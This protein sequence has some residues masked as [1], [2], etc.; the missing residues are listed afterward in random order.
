[1]A[2]KACDCPTWGLFDQF[3]R[4]Y[5]LADLMEWAWAIHQVDLTLLARGEH[6]AICEL[7]TM[8]PGE[9]RVRKVMEHLCQWADRSRVPLELS[10]SDLW[11]ADIER[12]IRFYTS[13]GF[14]LNR[15][16]RTLLRLQEHMIRY[17]T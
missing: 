6:V 12:L 14:Q 16:P 5:I 2:E 3:E 9:G 11:G 4:D 8:R 1:M 13:L 15:E 17:P 7:L 10:P